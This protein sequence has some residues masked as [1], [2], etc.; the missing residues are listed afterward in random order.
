M[1]IYLF[2]IYNTQSTHKKSTHKSAHKLKHN[3]EMGSQG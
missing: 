1:H 3:I 2:K